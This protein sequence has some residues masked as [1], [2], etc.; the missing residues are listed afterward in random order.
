MVIEN[1]C[2]VCGYKMAEPPHEYNI[3]PSCG[4][5]FGLHDH[6]VSIDD[7][8]QAWLKT[9]PQN[10]IQQ[11]AL[12]LFS[13]VK[14]RVYWNDYSLGITAFQTAVDSDQAELG[15]RQPELQYG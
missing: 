15:Y 9:G 6:N 7:L 12:L 2:P 8:R 14:V 4:T 10:P 5:E 13:Q 11:L 3:C 1:F